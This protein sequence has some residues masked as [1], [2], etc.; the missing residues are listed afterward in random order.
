M[1]FLT[2][3]SMGKRVPPRKSPALAGVS[4]AEHCCLLGD[5]S[6]H[7]A[8]RQDQV[9]L[10]VVLDLGAAVLAVDHGVALGDVQGDALFAILVPAAGANCDDGAFLRL[11]LGGVGNDQTGSGRS[12]GLVGLNEDLVLEW[13][14]VDCHDGALHL[15]SSGVSPGT[16]RTCGFYQVFGMRP[17]LRPVVAGAGAGIGRLPS[18]TLYTRVLALKGGALPPGNHAP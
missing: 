12:L 5:D 1:Y 8:C 14:D 7:V 13:L 6:Q 16:P 10:I 15:V 11:L 9:L 3:E 4:G 2:I 18:S 17:C